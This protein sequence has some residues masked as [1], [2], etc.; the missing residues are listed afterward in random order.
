MVYAHT[1]L[2]K[3]TKGN[4]LTKTTLKVDKNAFLKTISKIHDHFIADR[5]IHANFTPN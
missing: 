3:C 5:L 2:I 1:F 4:K